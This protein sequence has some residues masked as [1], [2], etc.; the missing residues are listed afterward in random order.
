MRL[1]EHTPVN[2]STSY[3][4]DERENLILVLYV[5]DKQRVFVKGPPCQ[6]HLFECH[7]FIPSH[8]DGRPGK[9]ME[10]ADLQLVCLLEEIYRHLYSA[11]AKRQHPASQQETSN[12]LVVELDSWWSR[13]KDLLKVSSTGSTRSGIAM[14]GQKLRY[15]FLVMQILVVRCGFG[16]ESK[17]RSLEHAR[18]A[19]GIIQTLC[20]GTCLLN[21]A[22]LVVER[23]ANSFSFGSQEVY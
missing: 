22:L 8:D 5:V 1:Q 15:M 17:R 11:K 23:L 14:R 2:Q 12:S 6:I 18:S 20:T 16:E 7:I 13:F 3:H 4:E 21:G 9:E 19:L 10:L